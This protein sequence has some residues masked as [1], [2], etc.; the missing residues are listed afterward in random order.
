MEIKNNTADQQQVTVTKEWQDTA[1]KAVELVHN[2]LELYA[3]HQKEKLELN[4]IAE[5]NNHKVLKETTRMS[6]VILLVC[7]GIISALIF[8]DKGKDFIPVITMIIGANSFGNIS[9]LLGSHSQ[10]SEDK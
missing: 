6:F 2:G 3:K 7:M 10:Q 8:F 1:D 9:K 5:A 4:K